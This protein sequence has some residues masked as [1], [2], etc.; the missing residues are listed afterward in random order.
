M[1]KCLLNSVHVL[2]WNMG[3]VMPL[4]FAWSTCGFKL[5]ITEVNG[6]PQRI[7]PKTPAEISLDSCNW[8]ALYVIQHTS[9]LLLL[10]GCHIAL[11]NFWQQ[12]HTAYHFMAGGTTTNYRK[13]SSIK[14]CNICPYSLLN[15]NFLK[16]VTSFVKT[17]P[18][19]A[20][21]SKKNNSMPVSQHHIL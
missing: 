12:T 19:Y 6:L 8:F 14:A 20:D 17:W 7:L 9:S 4:L 3:R 11:N 1:N 10:G 13:C 15:T 21:P 16:E 2:L 18:G 5:T